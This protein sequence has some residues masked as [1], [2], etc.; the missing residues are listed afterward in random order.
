MKLSLKIE[1][2]GNFRRLLG[3]FL[4]VR[5]QCIL[6][7]TPGEL[8]IISLD[9]A[10]P[11][12]WGT[13]K[14]NNFIRFDVV[15]KDGHIGMELNVEPLFHILKNYEKA[16]STTE[17]SIK[18]QRGEDVRVGKEPNNKRRSV[19]LAIGY[20]E[21]ITMST[22]ISHSFN[23]P[24]NLLRNQALERLEMPEITDIE[25]VVDLDHHLNNFFN[26]IERYR[27]TDKI[28][29]VLNRLGE[30]KVE[31]EDTNK[32]ISIKWKNLLDTYRPSDLDTQ[33]DEAVTTK[34]QNSD[35][36]A[37][38]KEVTVQVKL[39]WWS[40]VSKLTEL[41][42]TLQMCIYNE[43]CVFTCNLEPEQNCLLVYYLPGKLLE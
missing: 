43:G 6:K 22:E 34:K 29:V 26:R 38:I 23:I 7:F 13:I 36:L 35:D 9:Q 30:M 41:C 33:A 2:V 15:A 21:D 8:N 19:F 37:M 18:L 40:L 12:L 14:K 32:R 17:I 20:N 25:L 24:I 42:E 16:P 31:F 5:K 27:A 10:G 1:D 4:A 28:N 11:L 3:F 39:K